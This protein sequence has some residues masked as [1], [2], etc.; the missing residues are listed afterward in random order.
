[1]SEVSLFP[2]YKHENETTNYCLRMLKL[3]YEEHPRLL[4]EFLSDLLDE[5]VESLG[6]EI[7]QQVS[8]EGTNRIMDGLIQNSPSDVCFE[9]KGGGGSF[10]ESKLKDYLNSLTSYEDGDGITKLIAVGTKDQFKDIDEERVEAEDEGT[11]FYGCTYSEF[12]KS[13]RSLDLP[14]H[15]DE[16]IL[17]LEEYLNQKNLLPEWKKKLVVVPCTKFFD[18]VMEQERYITRP[19]NGKRNYQRCKFFGVYKEKKV[20]AIAKIKA[21]V[22]VHEGEK[23]NEIYWN[24]SDE[25]EEALFEEAL[26]KA[27]KDPHDPQLI[28]SGCRVFL[29]DGLE[30]IKFKKDSKYGLQ[31]KKYFDLSKNVDA[32]DLIGIAEALN[33]KSW[34]Q[35]EE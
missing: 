24:N 9:F 35:I 10:D 12:V 30:K 33:G 23:E 3:I 16:F 20:H 5:Q 7:Q 25:D 4:E 26:N 6:L 32:D 21:V 19:G 1:M 34:S 2:T 13:L 28:H 31:N 17:E 11:V 15:L 8:H 22:D 29:F 27:E 14:G 18:N